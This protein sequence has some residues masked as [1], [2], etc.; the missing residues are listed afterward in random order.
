MQRALDLAVCQR[1]ISGARSLHRILG[2]DAR[3]CVDLRLPFLDARE[4]RLGGF[5]GRDLAAADRGRE[6][7]QAQFGWI[8]HDCAS[9]RCMRTNVAGSTSMSSAIFAAAKRVTG[10]VTARAIRA[11]PSRGSGMR[12]AAAFVTT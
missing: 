9:L 10:M 5:G 2:F 1:P 6:I 8:A 11:A 7:L 12:A 4:Q 3:K